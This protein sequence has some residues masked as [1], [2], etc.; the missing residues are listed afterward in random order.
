MLRS[1]KKL[2]LITSNASLCSVHTTFFGS[3]AI[4]ERNEDIIVNNGINLKEIVG[5]EGNLQRLLKN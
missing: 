4:I 1:T 3:D 2:T 5:S